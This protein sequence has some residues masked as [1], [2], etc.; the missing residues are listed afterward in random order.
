MLR[1]QTER[2]GRRRKRT[3]RLLLEVICISL[4]LTACHT[5]RPVQPADLTSSTMLDFTTLKDKDTGAAFPGVDD[6]GTW[7]VGL[8]CGNCRNPAPWYM[9][10]LKPCTP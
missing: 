8:I 4:T 5:M 10:I 2:V 1:I 6:T 9:T 3:D 7:L